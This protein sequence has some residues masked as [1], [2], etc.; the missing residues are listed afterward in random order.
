VTV[1][2]PLPDPPP[3]TVIHDVALLA[4][5]HAQPVCVVTAIDPVD[6]LEPTDVPVGEIVKLHGTPDWVIVKVW[7]A[8][9]TVPEREAVLVFAAT[10]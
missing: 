6:A 3:V 7:P 1:P 8:T 10:L 9:V 2:F 5:V 4:A